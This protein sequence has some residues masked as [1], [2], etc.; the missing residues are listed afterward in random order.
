MI[1]LQSDCA[2]M[3]LGLLFSFV[4]IIVMNKWS[5]GDSIAPSFSHNDNCGV[6]YFRFTEVACPLELGLIDFAGG[7]LC[8]C[9]K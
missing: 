7:K 6:G 1:N 8:P 9:C 4:L 2:T 5:L 3:A